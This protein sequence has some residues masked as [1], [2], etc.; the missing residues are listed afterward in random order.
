MGTSLCASRHGFRLRLLA[1]RITYYVTMLFKVHMIIA[2]ALILTACGGDQ[3]AERADSDPLD[4]TCDYVDSL[5]IDL[6]GVDSLTV[7]DLLRT[8]HQVEYRSSMAGPFVTA[9]DS[10]ESGTDYFWIYLVNDSMPSVACDKLVTSDGD[11]VKWH[12]RRMK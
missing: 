11:R 2:A 6:V 8:T 3:P 1:A 5:V 9:I 4:L 12:F 7:F 10:V